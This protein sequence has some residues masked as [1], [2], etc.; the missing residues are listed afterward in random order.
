MIYG[1]IGKVTDLTA[2]LYRPRLIFESRSSLHCGGI[3]KDTIYAI[4]PPADLAAYDIKRAIPRDYFNEKEIV[5]EGEISA[6]HI[7]GY[8][9][10][11][12]DMGT[13]ETVGE[14]IPNENFVP[15][16]GTQTPA[17]HGVDAPKGGARNRS[18]FG[19]PYANIGCSDGYCVGDVEC[20]SLN[21]SS[22]CKST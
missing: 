20:T 7:V 15:R 21:G 13:G 4:Q 12:W 18:L 14:F 22:F 11:K 16:P 5:F 8:W 2:L 3:G 9:K 1:C 6:D 10:V 19:E 17:V